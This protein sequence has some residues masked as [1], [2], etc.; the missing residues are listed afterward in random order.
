MAAPAN[1]TAACDNIPAPAVLTAVDNCGTATVNMTETIMA[2]SCPS[3]YQ[4]IRTWIATDACGNNT[5]PISQTI[6]VSDT[7][8][9]I[10][11]NPLDTKIS[12]NCDAIPVA[13]V[14]TAA[15]FTD[16]CSTVGTPIFAQTQ[17]QPDAN[18]TYQIVRTWTV[19]DACGN[20][21]VVTQSITVTQTTDVTEVPSSSCTNEDTVYNLTDIANNPDIPANAVWVN[22]DNVGGFT[23]G[24]S[25]NALGIAAGVYTFSYTITTGLC[26]RRVEI[27]MTVNT[28]CGVLP[29]ESIVIHNAFTP[30]G[31]TLNEWF[32][33]DHIEDFDCYPTNSVEIYNRWGILVYSTKQYD[34]SSRRFEGISEGRATISKSDE[35][36]TGTYFYIIQ[37]TTTDGQTVN[38]DGYLYLTR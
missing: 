28:D 33:I 31:D 34:N 3:N 8:G 36:P 1:T 19:T 6:T 7:V 27:K 18:G 29:C 22:V 24:N 21:T 15:D 13:P 4:I 26:P 23:N 20:T 10:I 25:F 5:L 37:W 17:T 12:V 35:L 11:I 16:N 9:P 38:K 2:G 30:N 32:Q 14:L